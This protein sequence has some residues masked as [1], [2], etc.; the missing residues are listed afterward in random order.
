M[1]S[2]VLSPVSLDVGC[3]LAPSHWDANAITHAHTQ[4]TLC[5]EVISYPDSSDS[6]LSLS[7]LQ[8]DF[9]LELQV[10]SLLGHRTK[11]KDLPKLTQ[12][13]VLRLRSV[14]M[15]ELVYPN[16]RRFKLPA[17]LL[18]AVGLSRAAGDAGEG[19][20][21]F[22]GGDTKAAPAAAAAAAAGDGELLDGED[23]P[24]PASSR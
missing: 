7:I 9:Q 8:S 19:G 11:V 20:D 23:V 24:H 14:V 15:E 16:S 22:M 4:G 6:F 12:L 3:P 13:L 2:P 21:A 1:Y 17:D 5:L 18:G 10:R